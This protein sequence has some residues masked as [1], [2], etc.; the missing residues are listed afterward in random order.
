[1]KIAAMKETK[2]GEN[3]IPLIPATADKL[4]KLG[5]TLVVQSGMG[6][7]L[8]LE[9]DAY[10][11][12]GATVADSAESC[13]DGAQVVLRMH[14]PSADQIGQL[15]EGQVHISYLDPFQDQATVRELAAKG[16]SAI[17]LEMIPRSTIAQKMDVVSS[18][19]NLAGYAAV[20]IAA[21]RLEKI[22]PMMSTPAGTISPSRVF[23]I[24][25]GVA[26]LQ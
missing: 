24:G 25:A 8:G 16:I 1:M 26:G 12:V 3:R 6:Q 21:D 19:A 9:D 22:L 14:K 18:Q 11:K 5:A 10:R 7:T 4:V 17:S 13:L 23:V 2:P 15:S 20:V